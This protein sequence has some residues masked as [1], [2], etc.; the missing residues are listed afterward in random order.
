[1]VALRCQIAKR[2]FL[3]NTDCLVPFWTN[4]LPMSLSGRGLMPFQDDPERFN[5]GGGG[6][7]ASP[8]FAPG[9]SPMPSPQERKAAAQAPNRKAA[10]DVAY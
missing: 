6:I 7:H 3:P 2:A 8:P 5:A 9:R 1:M 4:V 10:P